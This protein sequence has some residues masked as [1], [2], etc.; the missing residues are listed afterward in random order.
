MTELEQNKRLEYLIKDVFKMSVLDFS[1]RYNDT[2]G[3]KTYNI[4]RGRN[5]ISNKMLDAIVSSYPEINRNWLLT[6]EGSMLQKD[7][8][9]IEEYLRQG[10]PV[11][12]IDA[13]CGLEVRDFRDEN[14]IGHIDLP[15]INKEVIIITARGESMNPII[16]NGSMISVREIKNWDFI[17]YGQIYLV[18][19]PEYRLLKY[20]RKHENKDYVLLKSANPDFDDIELS[21]G[22]IVKLLLVEDILNHIKLI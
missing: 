5:G 18:V 22:D 4:L 11:Y 7:E 3:V 20:V 19:T 14:I 6:G 16:K 12:D 1:S 8:L 10:V 2:K 9:E 21:K 15:N 17:V 13:T